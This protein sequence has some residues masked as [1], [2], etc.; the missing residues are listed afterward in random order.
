[1][2]NKSLL[3]RLI[4]NDVSLMILSVLLA[5]VIWFVINAGSDVESNVQI[6]N[7]P[8]NIELSHD[9]QNDDLQVFMS[10]DKNASVEVSGNRLIVG[11]L[12]SSDVQIYAL[13][14]DF[15]KTPGY[16]NL[17][18]AAKKVSVKSNYSIDKVTPSSIRIYADRYKEKQLEIK[19][20]IVYNVDAEHYVNSSMTEKVTVS[21]PET[22]INKI[23]RVVVQGEMDA[24]LDRVNTDEF[25]LTYLD[26]DSNPVDISLLE[27]S[28]EKVT[29]SVEALPTKEID[30]AVDFINKPQNCP[31]ITFSVD[32]IKVAAKQSVLDKIENNTVVIGAL[33]FSTLDA[34]SHSIE[35]DLVLPTDCINIS[36]IKQ[37]TVNVDLSNYYSRKIMVDTF[38]TQNIDTSAY[39][40]KFNEGFEVTVYGPDDKISRISSDDIIANCDF[41][42]KL[43]NVSQKVFSLDIPLVFSFNSEY[44]GC[45]VYGTY[46]ALA[47]VSQK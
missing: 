33:D 3:N 16:Y 8:I 44:K 18:L 22:V 35:Y 38:R 4:T 32:R 12:S 6:S 23:D 39:S 29:V 47:N 27:F 45:W 28:V 11:S 25:E 30:L 20:E 17:E 14:A 15:I 21:G 36:G 31:D 7:I 1:M 24:E 9:A 2:K 41:K 46:S 13:D 34:S 42:G 26:K 10:G 19:D 5:L 40:V 43:D 37:I